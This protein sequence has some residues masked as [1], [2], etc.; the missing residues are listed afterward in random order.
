MDLAL[1]RRNLQ[2]LRKEQSQIAVETG[3]A[4]AFTR[5]SF[6]ITTVN[7]RRRHRIVT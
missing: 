1:A 5:D 2:K 7:R 6:P 4:Q 3:F